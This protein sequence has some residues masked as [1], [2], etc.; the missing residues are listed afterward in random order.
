MR[1]DFSA[2][3]V[4]VRA[5]HGDDVAAQRLPAVLTG[6][7]EITVAFGPAYLPDALTSFGTPALRGALLEARQRARR[8]GRRSTGIC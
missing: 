1:L 6:A 5:G 2:D 3:S 8:T 7:R 4:L